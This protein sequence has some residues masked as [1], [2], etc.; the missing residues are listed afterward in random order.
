MK[1]IKKFI[2]IL[3]LLVSLTYLF[4]VITPRVFTNFYPFGIRTAIIMTGS[5]EP[6]LH[7]NDFVIV[8]KDKN[9]KVG[10]IITYKDKDVKEEVMHRVVEIKDNKIITKGDAN[11]IEDKPI[12]K[13]QVTGKYVKKVKYLGKIIVFMSNPL[14]FSIII[15]FFIIML[16]IPEKK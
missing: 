12:N 10:D 9:I 11:N 13:N 3:F 16:F 14:I 5:M 6:T 2:F 8:K 7:I 1:V 4:V 15:T